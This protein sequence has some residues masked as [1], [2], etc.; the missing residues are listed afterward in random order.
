LG[1]QCGF[2]PRQL[3]AAA[4]RDGVESHKGTGFGAAGGFLWFTSEQRAQY[5]AGDCGIVPALDAAPPEAA[6]RARGDVTDEAASFV[7]AA[8]VDCLVSEPRDLLAESPDAPL[9]PVPSVAESV[10]VTIPAAIAPQPVTSR[11]KFPES[12]EK[13]AESI[14]STG[15]SLPRDRYLRKQERRRRLKERRN[16]SRRLASTACR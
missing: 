13:P 4:K 8:A 7:S 12:L 16:Q 11:A 10:V 2:N 3:R 15:S 6:E 1:A 9:S 5:L 14:V